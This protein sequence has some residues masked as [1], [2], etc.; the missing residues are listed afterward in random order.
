MQLRVARLCLDCEEVHDARQCPVCTS[1]A[2]AYVSMWVPAPER[3][4]KVRP[5]SKPKISAPSTRQVLVGFG[6]LSAVAFALTRW[7][8]A[9]RERLE[10]AAAR[11]D[12]GELK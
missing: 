5:L 6:V 3:R 12:S 11:Q 9:A 2:F 10:A 4:A 8:T 7:S 1:E